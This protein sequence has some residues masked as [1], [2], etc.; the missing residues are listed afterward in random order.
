MYGI[1]S[2]PRPGRR[3]VTYFIPIC[4]RRYKGFLLLSYPLGGDERNE[5]FRNLGYGKA[6]SIFS[7]RQ[8]LCPVSFGCF[9]TM[10]W[11]PKGARS[12]FIQDYISL[13]LLMLR[14]D[15]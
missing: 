8:T 12:V 14:I 11:F 3:E 6:T 7:L 13:L 10:A 5:P 15:F 2:L 1:S 9:V 4:S